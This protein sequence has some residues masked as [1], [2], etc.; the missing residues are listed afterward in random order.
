[1]TIY[2]SFAFIIGVSGKKITFCRDSQKMDIEADPGVTNWTRL[3]V[4]PEEQCKEND[5]ANG[6]PKDS[7]P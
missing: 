2:G 3:L 4:Y 1:M 5:D 6:K 7:T